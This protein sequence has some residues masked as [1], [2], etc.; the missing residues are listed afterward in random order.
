MCRTVQALAQ[1][2]ITG[3][4]MVFRI[5]MTILV[6]TENL[7]RMVL[8]TVYNFMSFLLQIISLV[9]ICVVFI[10]TARLKCLLCSS[11]GFPVGRNCDCLISL[12]I[13]ALI[14]FLL[15]S[16]GVV[17]RIFNSLG[18][19]KMNSRSLLDSS[20]ITEYVSAAV[21]DAEDASASDYGPGLLE[22]EGFPPDGS[23][24]S[25]PDLPPLDNPTSS[26]FPRRNF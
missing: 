16:T 13:V 21:T 1:I 15:T 18:Y 5:L 11:G 14:L 24:S 10:V 22:P 26:E 17:D 3:L 9:P 23:H 7:I 4:Q 25:L 2:I 12:F 19:T 8:Q 20:S 6:M